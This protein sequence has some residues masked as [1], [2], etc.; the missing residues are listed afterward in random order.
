VQCKVKQLALIRINVLWVAQ[1]FLNLTCIIWLWKLTAFLSSTINE[2]NIWHSPKWICKN[3]V[4]FYANLSEE[5]VELNSENVNICSISV[6]LCQETQPASW[7]K[8][9]HLPLRS[10]FYCYFYSVVSKFWGNYLGLSCTI[11]F[12]RPPWIRLHLHPVSLILDLP[13]WQL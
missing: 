4:Y 9:W 10:K 13:M 8:N 3:W 6:L 5:Y 11:W 1:S 7:N 2:W 12:P